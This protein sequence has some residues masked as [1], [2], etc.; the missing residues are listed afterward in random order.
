MSGRGGSGRSAGG[1]RRGGGGGGGGVSLERALSKLGWCSRAEARPLIEAGRVSV[2]GVTVRDAAHRVEMRRVRIAVDG[3]T[4]RAA[5][6]VYLMLHKPRGW[7]TTRSADDEHSSVHELLPDGLPRVAAVGQLE[8]GTEG[9]LLFTNDT[10][11]ADRVT[12][13]RTEP[14]STF[15]VQ[16]AG[17][18]ADAAVPA[19]LG[20]A[21][22]DGGLASVQPAGRRGGVWLEVVPGEGGD[23]RVRR[24]C[25]AAGLDVRRLVRV[26]VGIVSLDD[27]V[28]GMTRPLSREE[29][30][31]L[32]P[33]EPSAPGAGTRGGGAGRG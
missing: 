13:P 12:D 21:G 26:S 19:L 20:V 28:P 17:G 30:E 4:V 22:P 10:R 11:W 16:V 1:G 31:A 32:V 5:A 7:V 25:E 15:H 23:R 27:L 2:D 14:V 24:A 9:V 8:A 33:R 6:Q 29:R 3:T 18:T